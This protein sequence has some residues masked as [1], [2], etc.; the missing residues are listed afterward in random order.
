MKPL[1][2]MDKASDK[3]QRDES[4]HPNLET[5]KSLSQ[6]KENQIDDSIHSISNLLTIMSGTISRS[7]ELE[8]FFINNSV[9]KKIVHK[10][11][12]LQSENKLI[13]FFA[14]DPKGA[15]FVPLLKN[16]CENYENQLDLLQE[17]FNIIQEKGRMI[18]SII[19]SYKKYSDKEEIK[20]ISYLHEVLKDSL[21]IY[22]IS[23]DKKNIILE[24]QDFPCIE[25][26]LSNKVLFALI[27][28]TLQWV[29]E[30]IPPQSLPKKQKRSKLDQRILI[31]A[32]QKKNFTEL[33]F[34]FSPAHNLLLQKKFASQILQHNNKVKVLG[35]KVRAKDLPKQ[36]RNALILE[37]PIPLP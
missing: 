31:K 24:I 9:L 14:N 18:T 25:V 8:E 34:I 37:L 27:G 11:D 35:G 29:H 21:N 22:K 7:K 26:P 16:I 10:L 4:S 32:Q 12:N 19:T 36:N 17:N 15:Q 1:K 6:H 23:F 30:F 33:S 3:T 20:K 13:D 28:Q 5:K 2:K